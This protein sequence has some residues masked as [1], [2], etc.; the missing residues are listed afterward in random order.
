MRILIL[1]MVKSP[2]AVVFIKKKYIRK[3][4]SLFDYN[5]FCF[6]NFFFIKFAESHSEILSSGSFKCLFKAQ[7][8]ICELVAKIH[9]HYY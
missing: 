4:Y 7:R 1:S 6:I 3:N 8:I 9:I 2:V 5:F